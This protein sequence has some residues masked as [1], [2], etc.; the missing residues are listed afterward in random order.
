MTDRTTADAARDSFESGIGR[1][2][3]GGD[4]AELPAPAGLTATPG[5]G[6]VTLDWRPVDGAV[7][8]LV[9]RA[10]APDGPFGPV[11]HG[12]NDVLAV[13]HPPYADT[14]GERD[15][16]YWYAVAALPEVSRTG[17]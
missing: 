4:L 17:A 3:G 7:G 2:T 1:R 15:R 13:P 11:D 14:S 9:H 5:R 8:Y 12:G 6:Q 10:V 16:E